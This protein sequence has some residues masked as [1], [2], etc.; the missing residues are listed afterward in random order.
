VNAAAVGGEVIAN[1]VDNL[2]RG[3]FVRRPSRWADAAMALALSLVAALLVAVVASKAVRPWTVAAVSAAGTAALLAGWWWFTIAELEQGTWLPA[4][5][6]MAGALLAAFAADLRLFGLERKDRRFVHDALGRYTSPALVD[7]LL[8]NRDLLD[9]FGGA[10]QELS[11]YFSDVRGF[12]TLSEKMD[13]ESLVTLLNEYLSALTGIIE[14]HGGYVDKYIGDAIMAV[15]GAP[16]PAADH[17]LRACTAALE[18]QAAIDAHRAGWKERFGVEMRAGAGL[19]TGPMVAGNVGSRQKTNYTVLGDAVNLASRLEGATKV[20]GVH[21]L[22]GEGTRAAA[23]AAVVARSLDR[24][25]VKGK[26]RGVEVYELVG[27]AGSVPPDRMEFLGRWEAALG[28]YRAGRFAEALEGF[29]ALRAR[30]P[31]DVPAGL[32]VERCRAFL[33]APPGPGWSGVHVLHEK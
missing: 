9:R 19:N 30:A 24:L 22:L 3:E 27:L 11:V 5:T 29:E 25:Q 20:Y 32:Y 8:R 1:A 18:M 2:L 15:W 7:T 33:A 17:A 21:I 31:D 13:P 28:A 10:R 14:R 16:V 4:L 23:G 6:P 26:E 12:T